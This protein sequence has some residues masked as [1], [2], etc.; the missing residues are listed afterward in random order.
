MKGI[1]SMVI[2]NNGVEFHENG[3]AHARVTVLFSDHLGTWLR[4]GGAKE[5]VDVRVTPSGLLRVG[6][7]KKAQK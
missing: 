6:K 5:W 7:P 2:A 3:V 4:V 1:T